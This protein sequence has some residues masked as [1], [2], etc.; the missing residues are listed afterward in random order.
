MQLPL[1]QALP[2]LQMA[3]GWPVDMKPEIIHLGAVDHYQ[4][5]EAEGIVHI[6]LKILLIIII[7]TFH[8]QEG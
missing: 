7:F 5:Q 4:L 2:C 3:V 8:F 1:L 6:L